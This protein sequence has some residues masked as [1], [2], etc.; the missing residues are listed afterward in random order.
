MT[1]PALFPRGWATCR[2]SPWLGLWQNDLTG[3][4]PAALGRLQDL[5]ALY[6]EY[7]PLTGILPQ[8]LMRLPRLTDLRIR[9][10]AACAPADAAFLAWLATIDFRGET[11][12]RAPAPVDSIPAET[13][14]A[15]ES[16]GVSVAGYFTDPDDDELTYMAES[17]QTAAVTAIVS[18]D[19]VWLSAREAGEAS[20]AVTACDPD[21]L[22]ADQIL[23]VTVQT[24]PTASQSDREALEAFYDATGGD[25]WTDNTNWKTGAALDSWYGV[26]TE[27]S[28]RV[29]GLDLRG[30][31]A[32]R[33]DSGRAAESGRT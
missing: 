22:C 9:A 33:R 26:T 18:G 5:E 6:L 13:L 30:K 1:W 21:R 16:R 12:N 17:A 4:V 10:T 11:C 27:P 20:V 24:E 32:D 15:P 3:T 29:T 19:T 2:A 8:D 28:G 14:T 25:G 23:R 7:N 31:R